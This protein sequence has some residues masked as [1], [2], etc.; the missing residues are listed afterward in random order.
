MVSEK[1]AGLQKVR[2][3][4]IVQ[5][6]MVALCALVLICFLFFHST[7][8]EDYMVPAAVSFCV[9]IGLLMGLLNL[10]FLFF[11]LRWAIANTSRNKN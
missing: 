8:Y 6:I 11:W 10:L 5:G 9:G 7:Q 1:P 2:T 3:A 4:L